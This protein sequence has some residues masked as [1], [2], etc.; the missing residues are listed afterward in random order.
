M[1]I[2]NDNR[3]LYLPR[4]P[5]LPPTKKNNNNK[6]KTK[7]VHMKIYIETLGY[8][9]VNII[10]HYYWGKLYRSF[11]CS[12]SPADEICRDIINSRFEFNRLVQF[13]QI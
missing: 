1:W 11:L 12:S 3:T 4:R 6:N 8:L 2:V 10:S 7:R 5:S 9:Q 13:Y